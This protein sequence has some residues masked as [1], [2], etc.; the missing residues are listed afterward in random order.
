MPLTLEW[1]T[2]T[3]KVWEETASYNKSKHEKNGPLKKE[4]K[5]FAQV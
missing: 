3:I 2:N 1:Q 4:Q 5:Y